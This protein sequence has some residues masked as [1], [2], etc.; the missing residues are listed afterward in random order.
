M[1]HEKSRPVCTLHSWP[2]KYITLINLVTL[3][4]FVWVWLWFKKRVWICGVVSSPREDSTHS[5]DR[6]PSHRRSSSAPDSDGQQQLISDKHW[7]TS[8]VWPPVEVKCSP[9]KLCFDQYVSMVEFIRT[10]YFISL[11]SVL[12]FGEG[13]E[14]LWDTNTSSTSRD[15][16]FE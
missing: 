7:V 11:M 14:G 15:E 10:R 6:R 9:Q 2:T 16:V 3:N 12:L 1:Y 5:G 4:R 8:P 13:S